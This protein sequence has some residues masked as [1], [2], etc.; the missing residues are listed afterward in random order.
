M[1]DIDKNAAPNAPKAPRQPSLLAMKLWRFRRIANWTRE[2]DR[3]ASA[4]EADAANRRFMR[5]E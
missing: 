4:A 2:W 1:K 3:A 5:G